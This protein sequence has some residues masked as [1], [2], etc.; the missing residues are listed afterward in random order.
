MAMKKELIASLLTATILIIGFAG[1]VLAEGSSAIIQNPLSVSDVPSLLCIIFDGLI[2]IGAPVLTLVIVLTGVKWITS[3]GNA[4]AI[5]EAKK[6]ITYSVIG[7]IV[8][9]SSKAIYAFIISA[10]NIDATT[11]N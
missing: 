3:M 11:C 6:A 2:Y 10:L 1:K 5:K 8:L 7:M 4:D 9:L